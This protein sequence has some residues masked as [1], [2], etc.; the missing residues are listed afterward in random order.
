MG[1]LASVKPRFEEIGPSLG[2][3]SFS[4]GTDGSTTMQECE[5]QD[6]KVSYKS[7]ISQATIAANQ[8]VFEV[9]SCRFAVVHFIRRSEAYS[10][11]SALLGIPSQVHDE[12]IVITNLCS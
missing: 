5:N 9:R 4:M 11:V 8:N 10:I 7:Q 2:A 1:C 6:Q 12:I 3:V